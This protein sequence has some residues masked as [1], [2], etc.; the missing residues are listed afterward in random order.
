MV[1]GDG[2]KGKICEE[3]AN[4]LMQLASASVI[5]VGGVIIGF[6]EMEIWTIQKLR[7]L[8]YAALAY[9]HTPNPRRL[10]GSHHPKYA[11]IPLF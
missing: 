6:R 3:L 8:I 4:Y 5:Y 1:G 11:F 10:V 9:R 2:P 7:I